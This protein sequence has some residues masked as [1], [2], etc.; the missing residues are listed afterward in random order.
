MQQITGDFP[1]VSLT[2]SDPPPTRKGLRFK[3]Q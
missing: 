2:A 1:S 3:S